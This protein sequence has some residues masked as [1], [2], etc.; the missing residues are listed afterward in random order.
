[1][2]LDLPSRSLGQVSNQGL[3]KDCG[4]HNEPAF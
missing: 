2:F 1:L 4:I 3:W